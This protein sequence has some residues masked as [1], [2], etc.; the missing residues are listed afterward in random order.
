M[1]DYSAGEAAVGVTLILWPEASFYGKAGYYL[2]NIVDD[3]RVK[4]SAQAPS[5]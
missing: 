5:A 1:R 3:A 2:W 4:S